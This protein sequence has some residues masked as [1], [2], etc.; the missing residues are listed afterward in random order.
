MV[1][2][3]AVIAPA[4]FAKTRTLTASNN[5]DTVKLKKGD[6]LV[7]RLASCTGS[8]GYSWRATKKPDSAILRLSGASLS[9]GTG[10]A[11]TQTYRYTARGAGRTT[12]QLR[13]FPPGTGRKAEK[14]F[15][16]TVVVR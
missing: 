4:A 7:I 3:A 15:A 2:L 5:G 1:A 11:Q 6:R 13:Y 8:C 12:L 9:D 14:T 10:S 16:I